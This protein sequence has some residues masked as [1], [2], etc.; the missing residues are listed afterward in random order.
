MKKVTLNGK[1]YQLIENKSNCFNEEDVIP[2]FT[3]YFDTFDYVLGDYSYGKL[4][5]EG[6][7]DSTS[8]K[9]TKINDVS[10]WKEYVKSY[11][12]YDCN[13]FLLKKEK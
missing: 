10:R 3:E 1:I 4:R 12:A 2:K 13:Y 9:K 6:F 7:Y 5:L 8:N 11:C